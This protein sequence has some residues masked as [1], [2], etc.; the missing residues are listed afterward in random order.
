MCLDNIHVEIAVDAF[1]KLTAI[2]ETVNKEGVLLRLNRF[3]YVK[4]Q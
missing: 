3:F 2:T 4:L 1:S